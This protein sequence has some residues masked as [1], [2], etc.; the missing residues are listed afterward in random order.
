M[1]RLVC[2]ENVAS[3]QT[4]YLSGY[5][6]SFDRI[7]GFFGNL[8]FESVQ[9][10]VF[11][12]FEELPKQSGEGRKLQ[13]FCGFGPNGTE[14]FARRQHSM[15]HQHVAY[16]TQMY[17]RVMYGEIVG[18]FLQESEMLFQSLEDQVPGPAQ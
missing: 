10:S 1:N 18:L 17:R 15:R 7:H 5:G 16:G 11:K 12:R 2:R 14:R 6:L 3:L 8:V 13:L 9:E 4:K